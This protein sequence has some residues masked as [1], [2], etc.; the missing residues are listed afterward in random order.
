[1]LDDIR[2]TFDSQGP[3]S[4]IEGRSRNSNVDHISG[5]DGV[6]REES[7]GLLGR[8]AGVGEALQN[9]RDAVGGL[10]DSQIGSG[11]L[12]WWAAK[13]ELEAGSTGTVRNTDSGCEMDAGMNVSD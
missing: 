7:D 13:H 4:R 9:L 10:R 1:M 5:G 12:W 2:R 11:R 6:R 8:E 3:N